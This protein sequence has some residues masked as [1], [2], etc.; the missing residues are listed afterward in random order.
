MCDRQFEARLHKQPDALET[1]LWKLL[2]TAKQS[3]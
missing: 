2:A 3:L 1:A